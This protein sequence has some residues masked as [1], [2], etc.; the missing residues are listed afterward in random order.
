[1]RGWGVR[2]RREVPVLSERVR[3]RYQEEAGIERSSRRGVREQSRR[4]RG[5]LPSRRRRS[6]A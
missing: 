4:T 1:M 6:A 3:K 2:A 5:M